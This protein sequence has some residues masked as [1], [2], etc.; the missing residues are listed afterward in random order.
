M[1]RMLV[2][3]KIEELHRQVT[4]LASAFLISFL[5]YGLVA[6]L[7]S[8]FL[9]GPVLE[10]G[11]RNLFFVGGGVVSL[12]IVFFSFIFPGPFPE[13]SSVQE[14]DPVRFEEAIRKITHGYLV[15]FA[16]CEIPSIVGIVLIL[17]YQGP[18]T[19]VLPFILLSCIAIIFHWPNKEKLYAW[20]RQMFPNIM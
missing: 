3:R 4:I 7:L 20:A 10:F 9:K 6:Y 17:L 14:P 8:V 12:F 11:N 1:D 18:V 16:M 13:S 15:R 5:V 19:Y 2:E